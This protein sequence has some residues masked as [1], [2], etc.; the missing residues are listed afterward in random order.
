[1]IF[2]QGIFQL[3]PLHRYFNNILK[4]KELREK[5]RYV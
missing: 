3:L 1:L 4:N 2:F 5:G